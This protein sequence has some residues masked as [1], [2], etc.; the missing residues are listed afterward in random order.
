ME[1]CLSNIFIRDYRQKTRVIK[2]YN[3]WRLVRVGCFSVW[4]ESHLL[5]KSGLGVY[6]LSWKECESAMSCDHVS[7]QAACREGFSFRLPPRLDVEHWMVLRRL[8]PLGLCQW[9]GFT[10]RRL[11]SYKVWFSLVLFFAFHVIV[12]FRYW[13]KFNFSCC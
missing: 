2:I 13:E 5:Y 12:C 6:K 8:K 10:L 7:R 4:R 3:R 11:G 9:S 1:G